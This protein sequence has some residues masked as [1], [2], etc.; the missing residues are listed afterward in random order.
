M[1][2]GAHW[3]DK[4]VVIDHKIITSRKPADIPVFN[5]AIIREFA[6]GRISHDKPGKEGFDLSL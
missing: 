3:V 6:Y 5:D 2:A 4:E 1:N